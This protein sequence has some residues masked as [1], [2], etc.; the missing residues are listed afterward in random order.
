MKNTAL[1]LMLAASVAAATAQ[2]PA[3]PATTAAKPA[4]TAAK[5]ATS[6]AKPATTGVKLPPGV[7]VAKG[8]LKTAFS[9]RYQDTKIGTGAVAEPNKL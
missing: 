1:M 5:P 2:T 4:T 3:K 9:L 8:I 7:P 6:A